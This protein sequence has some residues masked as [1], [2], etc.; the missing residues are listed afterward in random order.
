MFHYSDKDSEYF[1]SG[2]QGKQFRSA[3]VV[4]LNLPPSLFTFELRG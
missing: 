3:V 4:S 1:Q 2:A